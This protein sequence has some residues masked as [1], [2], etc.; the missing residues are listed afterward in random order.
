MTPEYKAPAA[1]PLK[2]ESAGYILVDFDRTM[3]TY[4]S[5]EDQGVKLGEPIPLMVE[6]I[7][8]WLHSGQEVRVFTARAARYKP[9]EIEAIRKWCR[10]HLGQ[11]LLIQNWKCFN[12]IAIWDDLAVSVEAN[13]GWRIGAFHKDQD[14]LTD[15]EEMELL[16]TWYEQMT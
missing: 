6:R 7:Q 16:E 9:A 15:D 13:T 2:R 10:T 11:E 14:P 1:E 12:C 5:L 8:R 4:T 3:A